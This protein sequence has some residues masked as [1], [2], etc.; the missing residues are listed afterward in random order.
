MSFT[1]A[2]FEIEDVYVYRKRDVIRFLVG[3]GV[4]PAEAEDIT[5][6]AFLRALRP[7]VGA[8]QPNNLFRWLLACAKNLAINKHHRSRREVSAGASSWEQWESGLPDGNLNIELQLADR[9]RRQRVHRALE[10]VLNS[11]ERDCLVLRS[12]GLTYRAVAE[13]LDISM[14]RAV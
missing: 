1:S 5:Q 9:D 11:L 10:Q 8:T 7:S 4:N 3:F 14:D 2:K 6:E 12:R 13:R